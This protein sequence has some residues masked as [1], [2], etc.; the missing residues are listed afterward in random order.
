MSVTETPTAT[1]SR[2]LTQETSF[3]PL[4]YAPD[5]ARGC[6]TRH[7]VPFHSSAP[8]PPSTAMQSAPA[9]ETALSVLPGGTVTRQ[10][11]PFHASAIIR[12]F[13]EPTPPTP[14]HRAALAHETSNS[15]PATLAG[16]LVGFQRRPSHDAAS[17]AEL[18]ELPT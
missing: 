11:R 6:S 15:A 8:M 12:K 3:S 7:F 17:T 5:G 4:K 10:A 14:T 2:A 1:H 13:S 9:Q 16:V 18:P